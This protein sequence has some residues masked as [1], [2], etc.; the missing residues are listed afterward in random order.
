MKFEFSKCRGLVLEAI[1]AELD[2][3]AGRFTPDNDSGEDKIAASSVSGIG[4]DFS[5]WHRQLMLGLR[6]QEKWDEAIRYRIGDWKYYPL[7]KPDFPPSLPQTAA[8]AD[9]AGDVYDS[10]AEMRPIEVAHLM[11][12]AA[13]KALVDPAVTD[14]LQQLGND[15]P[16]ITD[17]FPSSRV[18]EYVVTDGDESIAANYCEIVIANRLTNRLKSAMS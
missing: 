10:A 2:V 6:E 8:A 1:L 11:F 12:L 4:L 9:F 14:R 5:P 7:N 15:A 13:A 3:G 16:F 18:F 17:D